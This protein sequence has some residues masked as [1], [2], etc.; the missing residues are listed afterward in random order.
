MK[1]NTD[2][3]ESQL[4]A[5]KVGILNNKDITANTKMM[6]YRSEDGNP[7]SVVWMRNLDGIQEKF[8]QMLRIMNEQ[9]AFQIRK[10]RSV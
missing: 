7:Y 8:Q 5:R 2:V 4:H 6:A 10:F 3:A 9:S 1:L